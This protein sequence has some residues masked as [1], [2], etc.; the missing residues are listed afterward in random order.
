MDKDVK[1]KVVEWIGEEGEVLYYWHKN[2]IWYVLCKNKEYVYALKLWKHIPGS[3]KVR[4]SEDF[5][6]SLEKFGGKDG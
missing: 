1:K 6:M 3:T 4:L 5:Y 2:Q